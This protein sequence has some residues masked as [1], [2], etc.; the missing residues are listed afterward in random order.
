MKRKTRARRMRE[1]EYGL[2]ELG[3]A[4]TKANP[5]TLRVAASWTPE[6]AMAVYEILDDLIDAIWRQYGQVIQH[7]FKHDRTYNAK[8]FKPANIAENDVP[9]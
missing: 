3:L 4:N 2:A 8:E 6:Q 5:R 7:T 9:F 1:R